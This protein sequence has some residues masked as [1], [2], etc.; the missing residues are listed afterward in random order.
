MGPFRVSRA[1]SAPDRC[2]GGTP[3][4]RPSVRILCVHLFIRVLSFLSRLFLE[5]PKLTFL[6]L[7]LGWALLSITQPVRQNQTSL[8][9]QDLK[10][11]LDDLLYLLV[12]L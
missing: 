5:V 1:S 2:T 8:L 10:H 11:L 12:Y 9:V 6:N 4:H 3:S 7:C